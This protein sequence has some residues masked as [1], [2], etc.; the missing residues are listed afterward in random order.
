M[1]YLQE[2][3][4]DN[5][6]KGTRSSKITLY[7]TF[8]QCG[9][10]TWEQVIRALESCDHG[11]IA[12]QVKMKLLENYGKVMNSICPACTIM[13]LLTYCTNTSFKRAGLQ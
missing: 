6:G 4:R 12:E 8:L 13:C 1:C 9:V 5:E 7:R 11:D 3:K 2:I 10:N